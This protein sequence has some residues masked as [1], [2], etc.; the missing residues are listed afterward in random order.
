MEMGDKD[1][2]LE[3]FQRIKNDFPKSENA[4]SIDAFIGMAKSAE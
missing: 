4:N 3:F 1:K 2:A